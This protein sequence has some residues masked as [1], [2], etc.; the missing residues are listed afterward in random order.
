MSAKTLGLLLLV[1]LHFACSGPGPGSSAR[2]A[3]ENRRLLSGEI[4]PSPDRFGFG[5]PAS[6]ERIAEWDIDVRPDGTGLPLGS[7]TAIE[8]GVIYASRCAACHGSTGVEGPNDRLVGRVL[9]DDFPFGDDLATWNVKTIGGYWPYATTLYDYINRAMPQTA[10]GS[11]TP[12]EVYAV[13]AYL[14]HLNGLVAEEEVMD[15]QTLP[16][17]A[18]PAR[19]RFVPD[20]RLDYLEVR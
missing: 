7:G 16:R 5:R 1:P 12:D 4:P 17:V 15:A 10:P 3:P 18:M 2:V 11:L 19:D 20:D 13:T 9:N 14:L 8:G 6:P